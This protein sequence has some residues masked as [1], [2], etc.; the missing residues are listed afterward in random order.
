MA[1]MKMLKKVHGIAVFNHSLYCLVQSPE[2]AYAKGSRVLAN[3]KNR[4]GG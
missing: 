4:V 2:M 3:P 1:N